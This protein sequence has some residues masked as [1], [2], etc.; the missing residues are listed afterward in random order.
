MPG[1][2]LSRATIWGTSRAASR[3]ALSPQVGLTMGATG[4]VTAGKLAA[5]APRPASGSCAA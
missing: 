3:P 2:S 4:R 5:G 1:C